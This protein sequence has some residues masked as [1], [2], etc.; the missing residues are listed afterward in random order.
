MTTIS[1]YKKKE[2]IFIKAYLKNGYDRKKAA[3][4]AG[5]P[6]EVAKQA[7]YKILK[8]SRIKSILTRHTKDVEKRLEVTFG[9]K[10]E[11]L[12]DCVEKSMAGETNEKNLPDVG[13]AVKSI[14]EMNKMQGHYSPEKIMTTTVEADPDK[15]LAKDLLEKYKKDF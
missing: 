6:A 4:D 13:N 8:S 1:E 12:K 2:K 3:M 15:E 5:Y 10:L 14:A 11:I 7:A 9:W